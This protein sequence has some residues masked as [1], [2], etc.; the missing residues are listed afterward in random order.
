MLLPLVGLWPTVVLSSLIFGLG[1]AYQGLT[2]ILKTGSIGLALAL[3]TVFSGSLYIAIILHT[4]LDMSSGRVM[5]KALQLTT[6][7][8]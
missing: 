6:Q 2:G 3:L 5:R 1:H 4:V 7:A 8:A